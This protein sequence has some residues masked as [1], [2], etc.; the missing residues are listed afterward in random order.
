[1]KFRGDTILDRLFDR[2]ITFIFESYTGDDLLKGVT[3]LCHDYCLFA[4]FNSHIS[5]EAAS[6]GRDE[7]KE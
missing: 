2:P 7:D 6:V 5:L 3:C 4:G 1:M